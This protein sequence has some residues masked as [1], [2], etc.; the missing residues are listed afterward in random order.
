MIGFI[1]YFFLLEMFMIVLLF[2]ILF[3]LNI[4]LYCFLFLL[5]K[6]MVW[7][8]IKHGENNRFLRFLEGMISRFNKIDVE[9]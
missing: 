1:I 4:L 8:K 6:L 3:I 5:M 9:L 7:L 2:S